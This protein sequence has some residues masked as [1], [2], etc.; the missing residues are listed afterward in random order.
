MP[1]LQKPS[2]ASEGP[3][4]ENMPLSKMVTSLSKTASFQIAKPNLYF[5]NPL[6]ASHYMF[7]TRK[8]PT[9]EHCLVGSTRTQ[10]KK[11]SSEATSCMASAA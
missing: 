1:R 11:P 9:L 7:G 10:L 4:E 3:F 5:E 8:L 2:Q 6:G